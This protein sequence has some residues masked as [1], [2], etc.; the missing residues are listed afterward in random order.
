M[1]PIRRGRRHQNGSHQN[2]QRSVP[3]TQPQP[4]LALRDHPDHVPED[5]SDVV[6][7]E[8]DFFEPAV[9]QD[10]E[11]RLPPHLLGAS[12]HEKLCFMRSILTRNLPSPEKRIMVGIRI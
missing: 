3:Y 7:P 11:R 2:E 5:Y 12:R 9:Y 8:T 6:N 1:A 10:M 4:L